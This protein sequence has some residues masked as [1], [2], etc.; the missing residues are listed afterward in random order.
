LAVG[1]WAGRSRSTEPVW[2]PADYQLSRITLSQGI[3]TQ[4]AISP[5]GTLIAYTSDQA[6]NGD[7]DIWVQQTSG[8]GAVRL[9]DN[10]ASDS[11]PSFSPDGSRIAFRSNRAGGGIY[12]VAALGGEERLIVERGH[13]PRYSPDGRQIVFWRGPRNFFG[14]SQMFLV[15][16]EGGTPRQLLADFLSASCPVWLPDGKHLLFR[17]RRRGGPPD[18]WVVSLDEKTIAETGAREVLRAPF[19]G[20]VCPEQFD[21]QTNEIVFAYQAGGDSSNIWRLPLSMGDFKVQGPARRVT[22]GSGL[23]SNPALGRDGRMAYCSASLRY[24]LWRLPVDH[25]SGKARGEPQPITSD[26][27]FDITPQAS[28]DGRFIAYVSVRPGQRAIW[29]RNLQT[30]ESRQVIE[31]PDADMSPVL[32]RDG[33]QLAYSRRERPR[34]RSIYVVSTN[35]GDLPRKVCERCGV[36]RGWFS[37]G[38]RLLVQAFRE[39]PVIEVLDIATQQSRGILSAAE[40][41]VHMARLSPDEQWI[42]FTHRLDVNRSRIIIAPFHDGQP[43]PESEW[44]AVTEGATT[45]DRPTW[46]PDGRRLYFTSDRSGFTGLY[47]RALD[48]K[49]K[50]P[51]GEV[52]VVRDFQQITR[53]IDMDANDV[54]LGRTAEALIFPVAEVSGNI[55]LMQPRVETPVEPTE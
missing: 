38:R 15:P 21:A 40:A 46:S 41:G 51:A 22:F 23:E 8:G 7:L 31:S 42:A 10:P 53:S 30:G 4:P 44:I 50:Q 48:P 20:M 45:D 33:A 27:A 55:W 14:P 12:V 43:T 39:R 52:Q 1:F 32:S 13:Q 24:N 3:S 49:T 18:W 2:N 16:S 26:L 37:D 6:G 11:D 29:I 25:A 34:E 17:G 36:A 28:E 19:P 54:S 47:T 35:G 5:D 9:T